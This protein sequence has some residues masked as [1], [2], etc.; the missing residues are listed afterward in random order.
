MAR[1]PQRLID[2]PPAREPFAL[3]STTFTSPERAR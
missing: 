2:P 1:Q 3:R